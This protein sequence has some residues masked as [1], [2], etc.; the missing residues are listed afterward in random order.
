MERTSAPSRATLP[1]ALSMARHM[2]PVWCRTPHAYTTSACGSEARKGSSRTEPCMIAHIPGSMPYRARTPDAVSI[3]CGSRSK[4]MTRVAPSRQ[5]ASEKRPLPQPMSMK[6]L[7]SR[8]EMPRSWRKDS[9]A[10]WAR[11]SKR[12]LPAK[13]AQFSP[14]RKTRGLSLGIMSSSSRDGSRS[15]PSP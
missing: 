13:V 10:N 8:H 11:R 15:P 3:D 4:Q 2:L 7:P 12:S 1:H 14:K 6:T 5:A 9:W